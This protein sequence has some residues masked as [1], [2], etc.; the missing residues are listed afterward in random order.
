MVWSFTVFQKRL[1]IISLIKNDWQ[2]SKWICI[3]LNTSIR[4]KSNLISIKLQLDIWHVSKSAARKRREVNC[5]PQQ[6]VQICNKKSLRNFSQANYHSIFQVPWMILKYSTFG[7]AHFPARRPVIYLYTKSTGKS[8]KKGGEVYGAH[9]G[10]LTLELKQIWGC[11]SMFLLFQ[12]SFG[13]FSEFHVS[14]GVQN[15]CGRNFG[16]NPINQYMTMSCW[17][18]LKVQIQ[19]P[20]TQKLT[21]RV[22]W[23][24]GEQATL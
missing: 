24:R 15:I 16:K 21:A 7:Q 6:M 1:V 20:Q 10:K 4:M 14:F 12:D 8:D 18:D 5:I 13:V 23:V 17:C 9:P 3:V 2:K 22:P 19:S 11:I